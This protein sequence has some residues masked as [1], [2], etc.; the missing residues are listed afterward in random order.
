MPV[1]VDHRSLI[2]ITTTI[3][4]NSHQKLAAHLFVLSFRDSLSDSDLSS[5]ASLALF[6]RYEFDVQLCFS[7]F[8]SSFAIVHR[9]SREREDQGASHGI[10][11]GVNIEPERLIETLYLKLSVQRLVDVEIMP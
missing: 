5:S 7:S 1:P 8:L 10:G 11:T 2:I 4:L 6:L 3:I 9:F